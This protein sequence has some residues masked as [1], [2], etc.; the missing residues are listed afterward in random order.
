MAI[1]T[2]SPPF[3]GLNLYEKKSRNAAGAHAR[4]CQRRK[5]GLKPTGAISVAKAVEVRV[6]TVHSDLNRFNRSHCTLTRYAVS[7]WTAQPTTIAVTPNATPLHLGSTV[8]PPLKTR[9][10]LSR[11]FAAY[12]ARL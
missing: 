3:S 12:T 5:S 6:Y 8:S 11:A 2:P 1:E 9:R 7:L 10:A 4:Y